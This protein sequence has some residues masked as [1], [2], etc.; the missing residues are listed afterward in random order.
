MLH[1][2][3]ENQRGFRPA[4]PGLSRV[5]G[6]CAAGRNGLVADLMGCL[7]R[8]HTT[9]IAGRFP[10]P[11]PPSSDEFR[12]ILTSLIRLHRY[13]EVCE[14]GGGRQPCLRTPAVEELGLDYSILD[15]SE[16]QLAA[17]PPRYNKI[18]SAI[19][20]MRGTERFDFMFSRMVFEHIKNAMAAYENIYRLIRPGG[21]CVNYHPT[22]F[23]IPFVLNKL[24]P[25]QLGFAL[26]RALV[27]QRMKGGTKFPAYYSLCRASG[28]TEEK[29]RSLGFR[30]VC[31]VPFFGHRY[32]RKIPL[33][34][35]LQ[36]KIAEYCYCRDM[37]GWAS[38]SLTVV[39]K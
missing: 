31:I 6:G 19:E 17:A 25:E 29:L 4:Q 32:Y 3:R 10:T 14:V 24:L 7:P 26:L 34:D 9:P 37:R 16:E 28:A 12:S 13:R 20:D 36:S 33:A 21:M 15:A 27:P 11:A 30:D 23:A 18:H 1:L 8:N 39:R 22:L 38:Y 5:P 35:S 2:A